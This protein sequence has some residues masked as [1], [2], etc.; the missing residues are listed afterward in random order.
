MYGVGGINFKGPAFKIV[1]NKKFLSIHTVNI[2][3]I[4]LTADRFFVLIQIKGRNHAAVCGFVPYLKYFT[5]GL[6]IV[7]Q[8]I[9]C[10]ESGILTS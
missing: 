1:V 2:C 5:V 8:A 7:H 9:P 4:H 3:G 6:R 10:R